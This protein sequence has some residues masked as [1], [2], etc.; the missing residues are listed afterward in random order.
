MAKDFDH[1]TLAEYLDGARPKK[2]S[3]IASSFSV[4]IRTVQRR[5]AD[6]R[7]RLPGVQISFEEIGGERAY[8]CT[9]NPGNMVPVARQKDV[10]TMHQ[11]RMAADMF[12]TL[13]LFDYADAFDE[14]VRHLMSG[15]PHK[16]SQ[17]Y[18]KSLERLAEREAIMLEGRA[19]LFNS[20]ITKQIR[21]ALLAGRKAVFHLSSG[22]AIPGFPEKLTFDARLGAGVEVMMEDGALTGL[23]LSEIQSVQGVEDLWRDYFS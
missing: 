18:R 17:S 4:S 3:E 6:I 21:L 2:L 7:D 1:I 20:R 13:G 16:D 14:H 8:W 22:K 15:V 5:I 9:R 23:D 10:V 11:M 12:R 19:P